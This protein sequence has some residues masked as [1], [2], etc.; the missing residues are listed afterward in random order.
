MYICKKEINP[1]L[2]NFRLERRGD[3]GMFAYFEICSICAK[4]IT[5]LLR[6]KKL[7]KKD[8]KK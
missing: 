8:G 3:V 5:K 6:D 1:K 7:I 2:E 4:P